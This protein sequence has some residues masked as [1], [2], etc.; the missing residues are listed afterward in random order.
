VSEL[1]PLKL[2]IRY[3]CMALDD[4]RHLGWRHLRD[5]SAPIV[6]FVL[7][8]P[9]FGPLV[10]AIAAEPGHAAGRRLIFICCALT[11]IGTWSPTAAGGARSAHP[12]GWDGAARLIGLRKRAKPGGRTSPQPA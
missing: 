12:A 1:S 2:L 9:D 7:A 8:L 4:R 5:L 6:G 11:I 3:R 10:P